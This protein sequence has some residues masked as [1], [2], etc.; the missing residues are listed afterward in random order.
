MLHL[1]ERPRRSL[2]AEPP[3]IPGIL[4]EAGIAI[5]AAIAIEEGILIDD[6]GEPA[7]AEFDYHAG[8]PS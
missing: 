2:P 7:P 5:E 8:N 3:K 6:A 4:I 1:I